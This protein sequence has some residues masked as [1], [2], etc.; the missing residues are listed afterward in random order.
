MNCECKK[1]MEDLIR[2][3][4]QDDLPE[5]ARDL[6]VHLQGYGLVIDGGK[7]STRQCMPAQF[8][9]MAP[10][11]GGGEKLVKGTTNMVATYCMFC[12]KKYPREKADGA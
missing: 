3:R 12:G 11:K 8:A 10:K 7:A 5:G 9:Y 6:S 4:M 2:D 1:R